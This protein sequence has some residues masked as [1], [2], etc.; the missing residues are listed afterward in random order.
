MKAIAIE[1]IL[2]FY[3][4]MVSAATNAFPDHLSIVSIS[5]VPVALSFTGKTELAVGMQTNGFIIAAVTPTAITLKR[6]DL[7]IK[8]L[9]G[10]ITPFRD[11]IVVI[12]N[13]SDGKQYTAR[14]GGE[15]VIGECTFTVR[16]VNM[17]DTSCTIEDVQ[18]G[19][20]LTLKKE[21]LLLPASN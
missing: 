7:T 9:K 8:L 1:L 11:Y 18:T 2:L 6:A 3:C 21:A 12:I 16:N 10:Q 14:I 5:E 13:R 15:V 19:E 17:K 20:V 4:C